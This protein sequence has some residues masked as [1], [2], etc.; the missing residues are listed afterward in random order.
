MWAGFLV[1]FSAVPAQAQGQAPFGVTMGSQISKYPTCEKTELAGWYKCDSLPR[2]HAGFEFYSIQA[3]P[4][5][6]VCFVKGVGNDIKRDARGVMTRAA[7]KKLAEQI[8]QTYGPH[9]RTRDELSSRS[10]LKNP[11][12]WMAAVEKD[13]RTFS[14]DWTRGNYPNDIDSIHVFARATSGETGYAVVEFYF[15]NDK[16]CDDELDKEAF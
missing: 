2:S 5:I 13:E 16:Q 6:G 7:I 4:K 9:D 11:E 10:T 15:K 12:D 14:Y 1:L 3:H 8:E